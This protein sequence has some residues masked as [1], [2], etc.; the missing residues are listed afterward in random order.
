M[1][2]L[3]AFLP[4]L[5][6]GILLVGFRLPASRAMPLSYIVAAGLALFV[7]Q[8]PGVRV[9][10]ASVKGLMIAFQLSIFLKASNA[11]LG[12]NLGYS[13]AIFDLTTSFVHALGLYLLSESATT[14]PVRGA[15]QLKNGNRMYYG[16]EIGA[17][18]PTP[19]Q[20]E[21]IRIFN[22]PFTSANV[23][24]FTNSFKCNESLLGGILET[25]V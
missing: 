11:I 13:K 23:N 7:W 16:I 25:S 14:I 15:K 10:A 19:Q 8:V 21:D 12:R 9:A 6:V 4:I 18:G 17:S 5:A 3:L 22:S 2:A 24:I 1:T 20:S